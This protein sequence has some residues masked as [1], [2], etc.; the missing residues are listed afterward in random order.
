MVDRH[1][2]GEPAPQQDDAY[3]ELGRLWFRKAR[4]WSDRSPLFWQTVLR[5]LS[6]PVE[7]SISGEIY[8]VETSIA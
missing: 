7:E 1:R 4:R 8:N 6:V 2:S 5:I 3:V